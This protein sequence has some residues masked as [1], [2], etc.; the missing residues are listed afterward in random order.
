MKRAGSWG[1]LLLAV[2]AASPASA[3][4]LSRINSV[5][6]GLGAEGLS[7]R[8]RCEITEN[9]KREMIMVA[10][11]PIFQVTPVQL[12]DPLIPQAKNRLSDLVAKVS[13]VRMDFPDDKPELNYWAQLK[14]TE[15]R[16]LLLSVQD[17]KVVAEEGSAEARTLV[18][19]LERVCFNLK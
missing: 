15:P 7:D 4:V 13:G 10:G 1:V 2:G 18:K 9:E 14:S 16:K 8:G 6:T 5:R 11:N 12:V 19:L 17:G 3:F